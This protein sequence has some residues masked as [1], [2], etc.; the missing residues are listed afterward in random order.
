M[1][2]LHDYLEFSD[3]NE[4]PT[5][6]HIW[7]VFVAVAS[8]LGRKVWIDYG[9]QWLYPHIY[10]VLVGPAGLRKST[11]MFQAK[12]LMRDAGGVSFAAQLESSQGLIKQMAENEVCY[13]YNGLPK[14]YCP[15]TV[16]VGEL[17]DFL[18]V[19]MNT[20]INFTTAVWDQDVYDY[21]LRNKEDL[22]ITNPCLNILACDTPEWITSSLRDDIISGG[23]S[24]RTAFVFEAI[25]R[26]A[27][28]FPEITP[29][30]A[31]AWQ[32]C[33]E[34]LKKLQNLVGQFQLTTE[35]REYFSD[36]YINKRKA[37]TP[38]N[39]QLAGYYRSKHVLMLK[40]C[41]LV[42]A[43]EG[44]GLLIT[45]PHMLTTM[46]L[47]KVMETNLPNVF[48]GMGRNELS[49]VTAKA[50]Q[51]L[52]SFQ[53]PIPQKQLEAALWSDARG[54]E[55]DEVI[56]HLLSTNK[57]E[58][59]KQ[60][61]PTNQRSMLCLPDF[62]PAAVRAKLSLAQQTTQD[63]SAPSD[64]P[65]EQAQAPDDLTLLLRVNP[66]TSQGSSGQGIVELQK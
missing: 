54:W 46:D 44:S 35:A 15:L 56:K 32:R 37:E 24:R 38:D 3:C 1:G 13:Q 31:A 10:V 66:P 50:L 48:Q 18:G 60:G 4:A 25:E 45:L 57:I 19:S 7:S 14:T 61:P 34:H 41:M 16:C 26:T 9:H 20:M 40:I 2:F 12:K 62:V 8:V 55:I 30:Q 27:I 6:Y 64:Q 11:A 47:L 51:L 49:L 53:G 65:S 52:R 58:G 29:A 36:W 42:A 63:A 21:K 59:W 28:P 33:V 39:P 5:N 17:K 22:V 23:F 43:C